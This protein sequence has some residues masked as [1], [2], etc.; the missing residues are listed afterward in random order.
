MVGVSSHDA[1]ARE[2]G[3]PVKP[4]LD[5]F[6][7]RLRQLEL[8]Y[9]VEPGTLINQQGG[10]YYPGQANIVGAIGI[11]RI[12]VRNRNTE[13]LSNDVMPKVERGAKFSAAA[14]D[15][16]AVGR[17]LAPMYAG[18]HTDPLLSQQFVDTANNDPEVNRT[19]RSAPPTAKSASTDNWNV[20][21]AIRTIHPTLAIKEKEGPLA[22]HSAD[23]AIAANPERN[24]NGV[25]R[26]IREGG[27]AFALAAARVAADPKMRAEFTGRNFSAAETLDNG[28]PEWMSAFPGWDNTEVLFEGVGVDRG[29]LTAAQEANSPTF[30]IPGL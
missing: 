28:R 7:D 20:A 18:P 29:L 6:G 13:A 8:G 12:I 27:V 15:L 26:A 10:P 19:F 30:A 22:L 2:S 5:T 11:Q 14:F 24:P 17:R 3:N 1:S 21:Y 23:M 25:G 9:N 4:G 16:A